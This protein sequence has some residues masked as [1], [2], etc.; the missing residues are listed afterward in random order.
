MYKHIYIYIYI[1]ICIYIY[2]CIYIYICIYIYSTILFISF[3]LYFI[4]DFNTRTIGRDNSTFNNIIFTFW[5]NN[6]LVRPE[7]GE[8][9]FVWQFGLNVYGSNSC[10]IITSAIFVSKSFELNLLVEWAI[11]SY[12]LWNSRREF[13]PPD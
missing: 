6:S 3:M 7:F 11:M 4:Q 10:Y 9:E 5:N 1:Y 2:A 13:L 8:P 12:I